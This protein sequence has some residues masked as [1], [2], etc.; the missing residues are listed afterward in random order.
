MDMLITDFLA[1]IR[2]GVQPFDRVFTQLAIFLTTATVL[3]LMAA[4]LLFAGERVPGLFG[5]IVATLGKACLGVDAV[6]CLVGTMMV[7][8]TS[9][10]V[11]IID[12]R[13]GK[14]Q[15]T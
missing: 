3:G 8:G 11:L 6:V 15:R 10:Q 2:S 1:G 12:S 4:G 13:S 9:M 7:C 5:T 14:S